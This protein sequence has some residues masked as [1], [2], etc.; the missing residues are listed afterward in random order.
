MLQGKLLKD[1]TK[2]STSAHVA[3]DDAP[4]EKKKTRNF[5]TLAGFFFWKNSLAGYDQVQYIPR[6]THQGLPCLNAKYC[7]KNES[8]GCYSPRRNYF[9]IFFL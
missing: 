9:T 6:I 8:F 4:T 2:V 1:K 3:E 5:S 7:I